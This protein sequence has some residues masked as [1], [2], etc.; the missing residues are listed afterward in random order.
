MLGTV[1]GASS[2]TGGTSPHPKLDKTG[3]G[4]SE[5]SFGTG[6]SIGLMDD[7]FLDSTQ[8]YVYDELRFQSQ[9]SCIYNFTANLQLGD[10]LTPEGGG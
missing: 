6:V 9:T 5:R 1:A 8:S 7:A 3:Y 10:D 2:R 4:Y